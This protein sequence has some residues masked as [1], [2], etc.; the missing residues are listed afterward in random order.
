MGFRRFGAGLVLAVLSGAGC[1]RAVAQ[2]VTAVPHLDLNR[3]TGVW[4]EQARLPNKM[5]K[6]CIGASTILYALGTK[7]SAFQEGIFCRIKDDSSEDWD[8]NG[9]M[10][11]QDD[12]R[13][14]VDRIWPFHRKYWVLAVGPSYDWA[15]VGSPNHKA[16]WILSRKS[17]MDPNVLS[18]I[19]GQ[20][21]AQGFETSKLVSLSEQQH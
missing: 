15:L 7:K 5:E 21:A 19:E 16:L 11:K 13:L 6:N 8:A 17:M 14:K 4:H 9:K 2:T 3:F 1:V 18:S 12:G 20:A 10:N